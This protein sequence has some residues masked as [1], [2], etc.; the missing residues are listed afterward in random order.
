MSVTLSSHC[1]PCTL[2]ASLCFTWG[3]SACGPGKGCTPSTTKHLQSTAKPSGHM[4][5]GVAAALVAK[6][7]FLLNASPQLP[8]PSADSGAGQQIPQQKGMLPAAQDLD[9]CLGMCAPLP[10]VQR[11]R[12]GRGPGSAS[13]C[14]IQACKWGQ[15]LCAVA[16][17]VFSAAFPPPPPPEAKTAELPGWPS[18]IVRQFKAWRLLLRGGCCY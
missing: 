12:S 8:P 17:A 10:M 4:T 18:L 9:A 7:P 3:C 5:N 6:E 14:S 13:M 2:D 16:A 11:S 15:V 1:D